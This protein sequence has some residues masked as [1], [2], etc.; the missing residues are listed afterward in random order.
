[1]E[2]MVPAAVTV[3][4]ILG[5][6]AWAEPIG[7]VEADYH[8]GSTAW[9]CGVCHTPRGWNELRA[10]PDFDHQATGFELSGRHQQVQ[11]GRCHVDPVFRRV[12][13]A[14]ADCHSDFMHRAELGYRCERCHDT[15]GWRVSVRDSFVHMATRFPL[16]GRH[17]VIDCASCHKGTP[18]HDYRGRAVSCAECHMAEYEAATSPNHVLSSFPTQCEN[19][20]SATVLDWREGGHFSHSPN[21]PLEGSHAINDCAA[22]H[23]ADNGVLNGQDCYNCHYIDYARTTEP[24]HVRADFPSECVQCH[25]TNAF[26]PAPYFNHTGESGFIL[27][28]RHA[29]ALCS[30][31]HV[32]G[33]Y[34][35][36]ERECYSCH[37]ADYDG[38]QDPDHA[39]EGF[40][41]SC[42]ICHTPDGWNRTG[43]NRLFGLRRLLPVSGQRPSVR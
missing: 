28:G 7:P 32:D 5:A 39:A 1:M 40:P 21:F 33:V 43:S 18:L 35:G 3:L 6:T 30:Q 31:C 42:E 15:R 13:T 8:G 14:C 9:D 34:E 17:A 37:A 10:D 29:T 23:T 4:L 36:T 26:R 22:C 12:G 16:L 38:T 11:C 20:H 2:S 41:I 25:D 19:C 24:G 27:L